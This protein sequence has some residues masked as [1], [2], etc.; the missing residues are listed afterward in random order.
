MKQTKTK[1]NRFIDHTN[2]KLDASE[3][4][5]TKLANEAKE[6]SFNSICIRPEWLEEFAN[7]YKCSAVIDFPKEVIEIGI[8]H[9]EER[10]DVAIQSDI[11]MARKIIGNSSPEEK[12]QEAKEALEKG[13]LELDPVIGIANLFKVEEE[14]RAYIELMNEADKE[15]WLKPIF[16]CELLSY[17]E[18]NQTIESFSKEVSRHLCMKPESKLKFAYKNSTGFIRHCEEQSDVAIQSLNFTS[19]ELISF[20]AK[21]LDAND[22]S[23]L[24]KIKAAGGIR[25]YTTAMKIILASNGRLS[26]I[27][28]SSGLAIISSS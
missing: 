9:C 20:I 4:E 24:I 3:A 19:V 1:L 12:I 17:E 28:T 22:P 5:I 6:N 2:L 15:L 11:I 25:D 26:H 14:L 13:A 23:G 21:Q 10:S 16:S 7:E 18:I 8:R 27:G